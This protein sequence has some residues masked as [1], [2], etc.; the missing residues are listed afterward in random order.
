[1]D[2]DRY[3]SDLQ[4][5]LA[6]ATETA[7]P[8]AR[9][10]AERLSTSLDAALRLTVLEVLSDVATEITRE[11]APGSVDVVLRGREPQLLVSRP[12]TPTA[13]PQS[14]SAMSAPEP[15]ADALDDTVTSRTT[16]RLPDRLKARVEQA[17]AAEGI[18]V[19]TWFVRAIAGALE[20]DLRPSPRRETKQG[21]RFTGWAR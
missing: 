3:V 17:A 10:V 7:E 6:A 4:E 11:I 16:L 2:I 13:D 19:N 20:P 15:V 8:A 21:D 12:A 14:P 5:R 18:S 1:M 9:A